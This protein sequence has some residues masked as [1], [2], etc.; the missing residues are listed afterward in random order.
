[1]C[2]PGDGG[3]MFLGGESFKVA[4]EPLMVRQLET[5][6][7]YLLQVHSVADSRF[8]VVTVQVAERGLTR[9]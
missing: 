2:R 4:T 7:A 5:R 8:L 1:M 3:G 6:R 9:S